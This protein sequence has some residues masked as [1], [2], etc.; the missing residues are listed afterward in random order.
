MTYLSEI[1]CVLLTNTFSCNLRE[2]KSVL[3]SKCCLKTLLQF[4]KK[5]RELFQKSD[6]KFVL[7]FIFATFLVFVFLSLCTFV[8]TKLKTCQN[9]S[10]LFS[11]KSSIL[12]TH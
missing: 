5:R 4:K 9:V 2:Q 11:G 6:L 8:M 3:K 7:F 1:C 12:N 10:V